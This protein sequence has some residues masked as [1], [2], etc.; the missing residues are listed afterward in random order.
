VAAIADAVVAVESAGVALD[1]HLVYYRRVDEGVAAAMD[2]VLAHRR[3][4]AKAEAKA[5]AQDPVF[6]QW[7][8]GGGGGGDV[9]GAAAPAAAAQAA[10]LGGAGAGAGTA[11]RGCGWGGGERREIPRAAPNEP[12]S[13]KRGVR[14]VSAPARQLSAPASEPVSAP[15]TSAAPVGVGGGAG[16]VLMGIPVSGVQAG[17]PVGVALPLGTAADWATPRGQ[18]Q[19]QAGAPPFPQRVE[20]QSNDTALLQA[21]GQGQLEMVEEL[22]AAGAAGRGSGTRDAALALASAN[23]HLQVVQ[24]LRAAGGGTAALAQ[25]GA[26]PA[27]LRAHSAPLPATAP[28]VG[29]APAASGGGND[30]LAGLAAERRARQAALGAVGAREP[31]PASASTA[32]A[33][34]STPAEATAA[35]G[36]VSGTVSGTASAAAASAAAAS[37]PP[38]HTLEG[39]RERKR[40]RRP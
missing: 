11:A 2:A 36:T 40:G 14:Q 25:A 30:M 22:L 19:A 6:L 20:T 9:A 24:A 32:P 3:A 16:V 17:V 33:S 26:R 23:G 28:A 27:P 7:A 4:R 35:S 37:A 15:V 38:V 10:G 39:E 34:A 18:A 31:A 21:S 12:V 8:E 5:A 29:S 13:F 1:V